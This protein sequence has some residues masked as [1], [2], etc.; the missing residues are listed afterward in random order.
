MRLN[1]YKLSIFALFVCGVAMIGP[2]WAHA[3]DRASRPEET[4]WTW[5]VRPVHVDPKLPNVLLV[6]DSIT[7]NYY[8]EVK[9][10]LA[11]VA[12]VYLFAASTSLGDPRL[13]RELVEFSAMEGVPFKVVHFNNGMHGWTY[14]E[15]EFKA[16]FPAYLRTLHKIAP[17]ASF[18]W[19]NITPVKAEDTPGP[20]NARIEA[21]NHIAQ[22]VMVKSGIPVDDQ[23]E[24]MTH[25]T[26]QYEDHVH[27]NPTGAAIQGQQVAQFIRSALKK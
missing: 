15:E 13:P 10:Q 8:P 3:Q 21:R 11:D 1:L 12:N 22:A 7:R 5:E 26:D 27:F 25:H 24:L 19:A 16:A 4:E 20:T 6:G 14:S 2:A 9:K 17:K 18:I 23:H